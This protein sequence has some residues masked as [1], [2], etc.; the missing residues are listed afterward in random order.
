MAWIPQREFLGDTV[1]GYSYRN[2]VQD[3]RQ[4]LEFAY[5]SPTF[6]FLHQ[7][8]VIRMKKTFVDFF[9]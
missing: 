8:V 9:Q 7:P 1:K 5:A 2:V 4:A 3:L 6:R